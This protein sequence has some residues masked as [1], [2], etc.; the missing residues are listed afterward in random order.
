MSAEEMFADMARD[1]EKAQ[2]MAS[3]ALERAKEI[4]ARCAAQEAR[5]SKLLARMEALTEE[6]G[7]LL[8]RVRMAEQSEALARAE[9]DMW[10]RAAMGHGIN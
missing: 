10:R 5:A 1:A 4:E 6:R 9:R 7:R 2:E 8:E 3:L